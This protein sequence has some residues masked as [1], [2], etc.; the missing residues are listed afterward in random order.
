MKNDVFD[1]LKQASDS[2]LATAIVQCFEEI[3]HS[4]QLAQWKS[5]GIAAGH[6]VE[7]VR[8]LI[9]L[10]LF[11]DYTPIS[12]ALPSLG[13]Q[14][15]LKY[16]NAV[17]DE[18]Y[19]I[20]IPR[21]LIS[22]YGIRN[23]R[24]YGH[25]SLEMASKVDVSYM[26]Q[27]CQWVLA[28]LIRINSTETMIDT[29]CLVEKTIERRSPLIWNVGGIERILHEKLPLKECILIILYH[30]RRSN[31]SHLQMTTEATIPYL[32]KTLKGMHGKRL[33]EYKQAEDTCIISPLGSK[34][35]ESCLQKLA[36]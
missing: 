2:E 24:G 12:K 16:E 15:L 26:S 36:T 3:E 31:F 33:I 30:K 5:A 19:R 18:A 10:K 7:A 8:R 21:A 25:L 6:F 13:N 4:F 11:G 22:I 1:I 34:L 20:H 23:K 14:T 27:T 29:D 35:A 28:E 17:G 9:E 32:R